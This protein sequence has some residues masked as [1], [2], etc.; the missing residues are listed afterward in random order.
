MQRRVQWTVLTLLLLTGAGALLWRVPGDDAVLIPMNSSNRKVQ[1]LDLSGYS[2]APPAKPLRLLF[3]HHSCGGQLLAEPGPDKGDNC[4]YT[5]HPN[6][7]GLRKRLQQ[8]GY[9][10]HEASYNSRVGQATDLFDWLPKFRDQMEAVLT[11]DTQDRPYTDGRRNQVVLFKSCF[12]NNAF[13]GEGV[14]P[15]NPGGPGLTVWNAKA[16]FAPLLAEFAKH[17]G[18]LFVC[19]T[20]PPLAPKSPPQ[21]LWKKLAKR[22]LGRQSHLPESAAL[23][24]DFNS[25]L[26][27]TNGWLKDYSHNNV[28]VFDYYDLLT[29]CGT[30]DLSLYPS[31]GG[32]DSHPARE[33]NEKAA[34]ALLPWLNRVVRRAGMAP[35]AS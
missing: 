24:R 31:G 17:P 35:S 18:V 10:V 15:G 32:Y 21:P 30:S 19:V 12:P 22:V 34:Q 11:C 5:S 3:I 26:V 27:S 7:G 8:H 28:A 29:G 14:A 20:A 4:I 16:A 6:G 13:Q 1:T 9:E 33:G 2:E 23:A 25:W